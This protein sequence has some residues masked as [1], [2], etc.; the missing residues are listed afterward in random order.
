MISLIGLGVKAGDISYSALK[1]LKNAKKVF[2][3]TELVEC[4]KVLKQENIPYISLDYL[5]QTSK[6]FNT[7]NKKIYST[8][9]KEH[10]NGDICFCVDGDIL[11][12]SVC[13]KLLGRKY[14][15]A[16]HSVSKASSILSV[17]GLGGA[18]A[19]FS[20]HE[21]DKITDNISCPIVFYDLDSQ[22]VAGNLKL[23]L[24]DYY[25]DDLLVYF[26]NG[27][28]AKK[29]PLYELDWQNDYS[30]KTAVVI[31]TQKLT[32]KKRFNFDDLLEIIRLLRGENGCPWD[33]VQT[34]ESIV[35]NLIEECYELVDAIKLD[36]ESKMQEEIGDNLL[37]M[38]FHI[39]FAEERATF[40]K[41]DVL[42]EVCSKLIFRHSHVFGSDSA[43][44]SLDAL[45]VWEKNK[46]VEKNMTTAI[47]TVKDVPKVFPSLMR[48]QKVYKRAVKGGY[49][50]AT[51]QEIL[52]KLQSSQD[53]GDILLFAVL[54]CYLSDKDAEEL[55]Y[56]KTEQFIT[57]LEKVLV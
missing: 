6:S 19:S 33:K 9:L 5:Y 22:L 40:N 25:G 39:I 4:V 10:K 20:A 55:L 18:Y 48:A 17:C 54:L 31:P 41:S 49:P 44:S 30:Y 42:S 16:F 24:A 8:L 28:K 52:A 35:K 56:D 46:V 34:K 12:D 13:T 1:E 47:E 43:S 29:I 38:A 50:K 3:R 57:E 45:S 27:V 32:E 21:H 23:K 36:D 37:Q 53:E 26:V 14:I 11:E 51:K 15:K 2:V 7:L